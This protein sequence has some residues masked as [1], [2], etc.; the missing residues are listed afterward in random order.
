MRTEGVQA[1]AAAALPGEH[2]LRGGG[3]QQ[4]ALLE[5]AEDAGL[6][7]RSRVWMARSRTRR[8][9]PASSWSWGR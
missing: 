3:V 2:V 9:A 8:I 6:V 1:E 7:R 5:E 4:A